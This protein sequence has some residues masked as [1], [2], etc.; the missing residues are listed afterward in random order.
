MAVD[1]RYG[2]LL[3]RHSGR[4]Q[5]KETGED[6]GGTGLVFWVHS[7]VELPGMSSKTDGLVHADW[8]PLI[9]RR[10]RFSQY[11]VIVMFC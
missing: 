7:R 8:L 11:F 6:L 5:E 4:W 9:R 3:I 1:D 10:R 2:G